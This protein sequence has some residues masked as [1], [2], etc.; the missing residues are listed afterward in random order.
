MA[1]RVTPRSSSYKKKDQKATPQVGSRKSEKDKH[2]KKLTYTDSDSMDSESEILNQSRSQSLI[3]AGQGKKTIKRSG[4]VSTDE[5]IAQIVEATIQRILPTIVESVKRAVEETYN[6]QL[7]EMERKL[8]YVKDITDKDRYL[9]RM[10]QDKL[11]QYTRK[12]NVRILGIKEDAHEK[13]E[14]LIA[15]VHMIAETV[16]T[17][18]EGPISAIHRVG[19]KGQKPRQVIVRFTVRRDKRNLMKVKKNL[20][21]N[22][23]IR[24]NGKLEEK[25]V[26]MD[27]LT[28]GRRKLLKLV[29]EHGETDYAYTVDGTIVCKTK[30]GKFLRIETVDDM[31]HLGT[32]DW[33][34]NDIYRD[35]YGE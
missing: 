2:T 17:K 27:D 26:I 31:F 21:N 12:E 8:D 7:E 29:K 18:L 20:K 24:D 25:V 14:D 11:E 19:Q 4:R 28:T 22:A 3:T 33:H 10:S 23:E 1:V 32:D 30:H 9:N 5:Q 35:V 13:E 34:N 16:G 6:S 15:A